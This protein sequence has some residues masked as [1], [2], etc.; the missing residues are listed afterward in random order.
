MIENAEVKT[1]ER[2]Q[3]KPQQN[4]Q[5]KL[6]KSLLCR[7]KNIFLGIGKHTDMTFENSVYNYELDLRPEREIQSWE[8]MNA[9]YL[10]FVEKFNIND[11]AVKNGVYIHLLNFSVGQIP[12]MTYLTDEQLA[13]LVEIWKSNFYEY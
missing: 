7:A 12:K 1:V 8:I 11:E 10:E 2:S 9:T 3:L 5:S 13:E 6:S 4:P